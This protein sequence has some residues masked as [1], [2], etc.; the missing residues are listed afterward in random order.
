VKSELLAKSPMLLLPLGALFLFIA[1]FAA[2]FFLTM[3][4]KSVAYDAVARMP[5]SDDDG[6]GDGD[7]DGDD[8]ATRDGA[9]HHLASHDFPPHDF[10]TEE[11]S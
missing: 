4:K 6:D 11:R 10:A 1:I 9:T 2:V 7:G 3:K 8:I 5:L